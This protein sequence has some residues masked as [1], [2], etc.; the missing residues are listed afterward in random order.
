ML[1]SCGPAASEKF[2]SG[3]CDPGMSRD[4]YCDLLAS[5]CGYAFLALLFWAAC[6]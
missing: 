1:V 4:N 6:R 5:L 2:I 3:N